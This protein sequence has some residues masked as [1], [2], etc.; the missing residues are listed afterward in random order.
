[1]RNGY[2]YHPSEKSKFIKEIQLDDFLSFE[3]KWLSKVRLEW[4]LIGNYSKDEALKLV[5]ETEE[6]IFNCKDIQILP[7]NQ[8]NQTNSCLLKPQKN[9]LHEV[10][11]SSFANTKEKNSGLEVYWQG[12]QATP[13]EKII[14]RI[15]D[16]IL[17]DP[18]F[19][20]LRTDQQLC[21]AI[22]RHSHSIFRVN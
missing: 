7:K 11:L 2:F 21:Y 19:D 13:S 5:K 9:Y 3:E 17:F 22:S 8:I 12:L 6:L 10:Y 20:R 16:K 14:F 1:M 18:C 4:F 15:I